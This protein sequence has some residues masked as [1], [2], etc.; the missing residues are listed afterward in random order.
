MDIGTLI[1]QINEL[2]TWMD[3]VNSSL[4]DLG[5]VKKNENGRELEPAERIIESNKEILN[6]FFS[7]KEKIK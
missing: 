1:K 7:L 2:Q 6:N 4:D 5:A 3:E